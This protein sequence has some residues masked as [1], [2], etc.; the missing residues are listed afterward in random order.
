[1]GEG[2]GDGFDVR[3]LHVLVGDELEPLIPRCLWA[4]L[5]GLIECGFPHHVADAIAHLEKQLHDVGGEGGDVEGERT[6]FGDMGPQG[7]V[8]PTAFD[9]QHD[10]QVD[11]NPLGF[12]AGSAVR[13]PTIPLV[14]ISYD[15]E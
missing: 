10:A 9:A 14:G 7:A 8:D 1:M 3:P 2:G 11:R 6:D 12:Y 15:L 5:E 13:A 4:G